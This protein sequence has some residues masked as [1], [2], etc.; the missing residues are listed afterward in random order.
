MKYWHW[1]PKPRRIRKEEF[2]RNGGF[3][4]TG[5]FR[6]ATSTGVWTYWTY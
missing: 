6:K 3:S 5:Q 4:R 2:Y 1:H